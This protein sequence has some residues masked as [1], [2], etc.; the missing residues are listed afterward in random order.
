MTATVAAART[1]ALATGAQRKQLRLAER[2][3]LAPW[4][5]AA[6]V[7]AAGGGPTRGADRT[8]SV[9]RERCPAQR[10]SLPPKGPRRSASRCPAVGA[11]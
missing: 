3:P 8:P 10:P 11:L 1:G 5:S 2:W 4:R 7:D 9:V 6:E